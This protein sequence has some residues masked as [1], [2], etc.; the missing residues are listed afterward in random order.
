LNTSSI[1]G[2]ARSLRRLH[3]GL[4]GL[5][6]A[7]E[8]AR[9]QDA[10]LSALFDVAAD[11][12][13]LARDDGVAL[14]A[15][16]GYGRGA[17][18]P[19]SD[20][21]LLVLI[22][23]S[24]PGERR[25]AERAAEFILYILWDLGLKVGHALRTV[26][27]CVALARDDMTI[28]TA[29]L[30]M[31]GVC[32]DAALVDRLKTAF[33]NEVA[34]GTAAEFVAAKLAERDERHEKCGASRYLV[35]P[36]VKDGKGG[37]RDLHTLFWLAKYVYGVE[38][39][40][41]LVSVGL[42]SEDDW[43]RLERAFS[44]L[45]SVR[46]HLHQLAGRAED[47]L[48]FEYQ[49]ELARRL[50]Y[51]SRSRMPAV[52]RFMKHY[53]LTAKDVGDLTRIFCAVLEERLGQSL[54]A[55]AGGR[56]PAAGDLL[57]TDADFRVAQGRIDFNA[58]AADL[59]RDSTLFVRLFHSADVH[60]LDV[61][62]NALRALHRALPPGRSRLPRA[63][64]AGAAFLALLREARDPERTLRRMSEAGVLA[65]ILPEFGRIIG[66]VRYTSY[67]HYPVDEHCIRAVG[68]LS[69]LEAGEYRAEHPATTE[70]VTRGG[71]RA[72]RYLAVLLHEIGMARPPAARRDEGRAGAGRLA[73]R[74]ARRLG[75]ER[76]AAEAIGAAVRDYGALMET[77]QRRDLSDPKTIADF[78]KFVGGQ[79]HLDRMLTISICN[80]RAIGPDVWN[81]WKRLL[82][83]R[84]YAQTTRALSGD[85]SAGARAHYD[86]QLDARRDRAL[87]GVDAA[88]AEAAARLAEDAPDAFWTVLTSTSA[89]RY[90]EAMLEAR[91]AGRPV[92]VASPRPEFD[93]TEVFVCAP[94]RPLLFADL[95]G[96]FA[97]AGASIQSAMAFAWPDGWAADLF[98]V[99]NS[100]ASA[101]GAEGGLSRLERMLVSASEDGFNPADQT[102]RPLRKRLQSFQVTPSVR[103]DNAASNVA[104]VVEV[105]GRDRPGLLHDLSRAI[106]EAGASI[107][108]AHI[109]T[110]GERAVD[111][112][113]IQDAPPHKIV[114]PRRLDVIQR[115]VK[116]A[117]ARTT[118][119]G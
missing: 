66:A 21:D 101:F 41:D 30:D 32:G 89:S 81:D 55:A 5:R 17:L 69:R 14:V 72:A 48:S 9:A 54:V 115:A 19:G 92:V 80:Q 104:T 36:N 4:D 47:K 20:I 57:S 52:E 107:L 28:R 62:P 102:A 27:E 26:D 49:P 110:Y 2:R 3:A 76:A 50:G 113:Y 63:R 75:L 95:A 43:R 56:S 22:A 83:A 109:A 85:S 73:A 87:A 37:L 94:D 106:G 8:L 58:A 25:R 64:A 23:P 96:A 29:L 11:L 46:V 99:Q 91:A 59:R 78:A 15:V 53:F 97:A 61:H 79:A 86:L 112:F 65:R 34:A 44:F 118:G 114:A 35:E 98:G 51:S 90:L 13:G 84:L 16:G 116:R 1:P 60:D 119:A 12:A 77:A 24:T 7:R 105:V 40:R 33:Q 71:D 108:S 6:T 88:R 93:V 68:V 67:H 70:I 38:A 103:I 39:R 100:A 117:L 42:L 31:R 18:A 45:W 111:V 82:I 74:A 10:L